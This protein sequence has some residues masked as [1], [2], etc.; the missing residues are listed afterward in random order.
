M[1]FRVAID[2]ISQKGGCFSQRLSL[3][4]TVSS[5]FLVFDLG[6]DPYDLYCCRLHAG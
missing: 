4:R 1:D 6:L 5:V 3:R 2:G